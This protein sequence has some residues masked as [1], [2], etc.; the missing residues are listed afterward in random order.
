MRDT[1]ERRRPDRRRATGSG[2]VRGDGIVAVGATLDG[3]A[4][5]LL[6]AARRR[7]SASSSRS[8]DRAPTPTAGAHRRRSVEWL[9]EHRPDVE[10]EVHR[11]R[12]AAVPVPVRRRVRRCRGDAMGRSRCASSTAIGVERLKGVGEKKLESL[13]ARRHRDRAR[14]AD[15]LPA[16]L[17][18]PHQRGA[19][20]RPR[21]GQRG[22]RAG[23]GAQRRPSGSRA[24][25]GR[26]STAV[27]GDGSGRL[28]VVVLQPAVAR[29]ASCARAC[30]SRCS[31]RPTC[32]AAGCR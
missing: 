10:V 5:A 22:A 2:I 11:R 1:A 17:G 13:R 31:A 12:P 21:A 4:I 30:R 7:P 29:D 32:T 8:I 19:G 18:R 6:D 15:P 9:A 14:P 20:Q 23:H 25:A 28:H 24:T 16:A 27:V 26:W 3:A